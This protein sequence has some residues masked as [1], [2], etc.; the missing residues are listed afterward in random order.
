MEFLK[1]VF[2][3]F[4]RRRLPVAGP[5]KDVTPE[6]RN[7]V[8]LLC[9]DVIGE[10]GYLAEFWEQLHQK[11]QYLHGKAVLM[12]GGGASR[13]GEDA[14]HFL[15]DCKSDHFLDFVELI[16]Q[17]DAFW[18][19]NQ[20]SAFVDHINSFLDVDALP[21][22]LTEYVEVEEAGSYRGHATTFIKVGSY[23]RIILKEHRLVHSEAVEPTLH[24]LSDPEFA[25]ANAEFLDAL[26][27]YRQKDFGDCLTK[28]CSAFESVMKVLC[29]RYKW[30]HK[31]TDT[32]A[33]L[34]DTVISNT[35]LDSFFVQPIMLVATMRNRL[36]KSHGAGAG[37]RVVPSHVAQFAINATAAGILLLVEE[38]RRNG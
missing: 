20:K 9:S 16:F 13:R 38:A 37:T 6:F 22:F 36:S 34:V 32:A 14:L 25:A 7:R 28:C 29:K 11:L 35:D 19:V 33:T 12:A 31:Q 15:A 18:R 5:P 10:T 21:Y 2:E 30:P 17:V 8:V 24:L 27:D 1:S 23:P 4:S 26:Q 3:V